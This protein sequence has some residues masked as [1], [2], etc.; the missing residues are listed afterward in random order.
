MKLIKSKYIS[1]SLAIIL[2]SLTTLSCDDFLDILPMNDVVLENYWT[3]EAD[4]NSCV[5]SCYSQL[6]SGDCLKRMLIWGEVRS[7]NITTGTST[8]YDLE[9]IIDENLLE[10][11]GFASW[12]AFY[13]C[14]NR[15]NTVLYYAPSVQEL[16]PNYT[17]AELKAHVAEVTALRTLCYFY[18]IRTFRDVP[19]ITDPSIDDTQEYC[20]AATPFDEVLD[21]L[22]ADL[23]EVQDDAVRSYGEDSEENMTR[24][25]RYAIYAILA[26]LYLW[27]GDYASCIEY[28]DKVIAY[29]QDE[30]EDIIEE[31]SSPDI[32]LYGEYPLISEAPNNSSY[33]GT[34][35]TQIFGEGNSFES[36]FEL[37]FVDSETK[38]NE[39]VRDYYGSVSSS[40]GQLSAPTY[41]YSDVSEGSNNYFTKTD[42]R[43][44]E[45]MSESSSTV[46]IRKYVTEGVRFRTST[47]T[48]D[49]PTVTETT[50]SRN[51]GNWIIYRLTDV[52]LM[53]AEAEVELA[54]DVIEGSALT[55]EQ[56]SRYRT[57]FACVSAVWKRAN[58]KRVATTDTL[59]FD[60]YATSR[61]SMEDLV[62]DERQ[63]ELMFEGKRWYDLVRMCRRD[64][65]NT[66]MIEKV[67]GKFKE[68][69]VA[70]RIKL[71]STDALYFPYYD[72][73]LDANPYLVQN[74]AYDTDNIETTN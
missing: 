33:S 35:Y 34:A 46:Y 6:E 54:G 15:C 67:L 72:E 42:C 64:G 55:D 16:D 48:G 56:L 36:I 58:N 53:K 43:Y 31:E 9:Q 10:S 49:A 22:I 63:R 2:F 73:E 47:T 32:E 5:Y 44:L 68:N 70:I 18:L 3:E 61:T 7:D 20:V 69:T 17:E 19:Y 37:N 11:N 29:K 39:L 8:S 13:Q 57:A 74:S 25:T 14:I 50:R 4:V 30:Y 23:E 45:N 1:R 27:Q 52:M 28:C 21:S 66:R 38:E 51:V 24:I 62:Y 65:S 12:E 71:S 40:A 59:V 26:D 41:L 60:D